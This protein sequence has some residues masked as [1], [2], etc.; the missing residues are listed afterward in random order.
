MRFGSSGSIQ[1]SCV[2][3]PQR[4]SWKFSPPSSG[5]PEAELFATKTSLSIRGR[6]GEAD[7]I[8]RA[9]DQR[10]LPVDD[11]PSSRRR[12]RSATAS[13]G[14]WSE[15]AH[16]CACELL[17]AMA[18]SILPSG[19]FGMP[20]SS[21]RVQFVPPS[22]VMKTP[23]PGPPL[24]IAPRYASPPA[25]CRQSVMS[26]LCGSMDRPEQPVFSSTNSTRSQCWPPS[27]VR[28]TPRSCCGPVR[29]PGDAG[30]NNV[31][32]GGMHDDAPD[33]ARF[34]QTHVGPRLAGVGG[35]VD[36]VAHHVAV[37]N[38][39]RF[40]GARPHHVGIGGRDRQRADGRGDCLS[41][42]GSQRL[43]PSVDFQTPPEARRR[44]RWWGRP[45]RQS[46]MRCGFLRAAQK[47]ESAKRWS[48]QGQAAGR[49]RTHRK[50][51]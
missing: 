48:R 41:N 25:T 15:S 35:F 24:N 49:R 44:S 10:P 12:H 1:I 32:I 40:A 45:G 29:R 34:G 18:T 47:N 5:Q 51:L 43:P 36:A 23:L 11:A 13:P 14:R 7:V 37:T 4:T 42:M 16:R 26:G 33:A 28:K 17:G 39:P 22:W 50:E 2:S 8:A 38:R 3:P 31:G 20:W 30:V 9:A 27:V 46:L 21:T 19:D 6:Y